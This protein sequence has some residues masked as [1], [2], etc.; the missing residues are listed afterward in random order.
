MKLTKFKDGIDFTIGAELELRILNKDDLSFANEFLYFK[1]NM[2]LEYKKYITAEFLQ[3]MIEINTPVFEESKDLIAFLKDTIKELNKLAKKKNLILQTSGT[4]ALK[5]DNIQMTSDE[6]Y[7]KIYDEYQIL[8]D[9]FFI[10]GIHI[11]IGFEKF[12]K[13]L[14]AF[15]YSLEYLPIFTA[16][17]ASSVFSNGENTGIHS[18]RTKIFDRL[19]KAS[20][21]QYFD[22]YKQMNRCYKTLYKSK[23]ISKAK[24]LWWDVRIQDS[25]KTLEFRVC[26]AIN[27]F[28]RL[29]LI[30]T[31]AKGICKLAQEE[32]TQKQIYQVLKENMWQASRYSMDAEFI[33]GEQKVKIRE[34]MYDLL[35]KLYDRDFIS[36]KFYTKGQNTIQDKSISQKMIELY[37]QTKDL[38]Q[39]EKLGVFK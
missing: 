9:N 14:S 12:S 22:S 16:L 17:S 39:I 34:V 35:E 2:P 31:L 13:A 3:S 11:H 23:A 26:D 28:D 25:L 7:A 37:K 29:E 8:L 6:R 4:S 24:D 27:D 38:K 15:N 21:P 20:I 33:Q 19:S 32:K 10:C 30:I 36:K 1:E 5:Q 18:Y